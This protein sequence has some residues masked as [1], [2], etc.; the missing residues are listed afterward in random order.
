MNK[1]LLSLYGLKYNPFTTAIPTEALHVYPQLESLLWRIENNFVREGGF[2]LL[3]GEPGTG[4]NL[5]NPTSNSVTR[6]T[7]IH[8]KTTRNCL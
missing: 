2:A 4:N 5:Q 3:S 8:L 6:L 7:S 1:Q